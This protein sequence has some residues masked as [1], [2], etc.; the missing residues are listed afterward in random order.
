MLQRRLF[1]GI[2]LSSALASRLA[3]EISSWPEE[4]FLKTVKE[5][6]HVTLFFLGFI[7]EAMVP[8][9]CEKV[10]RLCET[11]DSFEIAFSGIRLVPTVEDPKMVWLAG[12]PSDALRDLTTAIKRELSFVVPSDPKIYR[13]HITL[14]RIKKSAFRKLD[15]RPDI[16]KSV[17]LVEPVETV[18]VYESVIED[19]ERKYSPL[20]SVPL[21][22][23]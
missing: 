14:A 12:E 20:E 11:E 13:P 4:V 1:V 9:I 10:R 8:D 19:G 3:R 21:A 23:C 6:L 16:E 5:N 2:P 18:V 7:P 15:P 22:S 17:H